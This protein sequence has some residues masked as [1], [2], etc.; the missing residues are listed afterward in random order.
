MERHF[1][2]YVYSH[3]LMG[4]DDGVFFIGRSKG[5]DLRDACDN[6]AKID[7]NFNEYYNRNKLTY[8]GFKIQEK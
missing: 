3:G 5:E 6:L 2:L 7:G 4:I 8:F 1:D